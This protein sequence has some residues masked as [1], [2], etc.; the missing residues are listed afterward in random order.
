MRKSII[1]ALALA[2]LFSVGMA[3]AATLADSAAPVTMTLASNGDGAD[4]MA[5]KKAAERG[6]KMAGADFC[7]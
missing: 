3:Q 7:F 6:D 2:S 1:S 5:C 4:N